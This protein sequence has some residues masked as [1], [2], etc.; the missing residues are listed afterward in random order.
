M[1]T[2][3]FKAYLEKPDHCPWCQ[4]KALK[5]KVKSFQGDQLRYEVGCLTCE[6]VWV[7][8][9]TSKWG[10]LEAFTLTSVFDPETDETH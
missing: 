2:P 9:R 4:S 6:R 5:G 7:E 10:W 3:D 8:W 1:T